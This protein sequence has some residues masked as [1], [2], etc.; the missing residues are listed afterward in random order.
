MFLV[1]AKNACGPGPATTLA[2]QAKPNVP[3][4]TRV[5]KLPVYAILTVRC[6]Q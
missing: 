6:F 2:V 4:F 1:Q 3:V 5:F